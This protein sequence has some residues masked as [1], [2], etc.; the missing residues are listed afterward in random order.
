MQL[1]QSQRQRRFQT[2][3]SETRRMHGH[4][5]P[6]QCRDQIGLG[7]DG[8]SKHEIR[9]GQRDPPR[10]SLLRQ[11]LVDKTVGIAGVRNHQMLHLAIAI[12]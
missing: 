12:E 2:H 11:H 9:N 1:E 8:K 4:E 10:T 6:R 3:H 7:N 5:L